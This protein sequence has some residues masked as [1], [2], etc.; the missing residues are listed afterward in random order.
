VEIRITC[1]GGDRTA[2][3][4]SINDW[5]RGEP[6]LAGRVRFDARVPGEGELGALSDVLVVAVGSGGTLSVLATSL[7]AWLAQPRRS[8]VRIRI[9]R[10]DGR[11]VE[12]DADRVDGKRVDALISQALGDRLFEE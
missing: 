12:V 10:G 11:M 1:V 8:D 4:E 5:L 6:E 9:Q 7:K 2:A 3:V